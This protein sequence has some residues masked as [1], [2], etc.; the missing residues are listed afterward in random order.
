MLCRVVKVEL[1]GTNRTHNRVKDAELTGSQCTDHEA[2]RDETRGAQLVVADLASNVAETLH[3]GP[4][5]TSAG[6]VHLRQQGV[7][8]VRDDSGDHTGHDTRCQ[9]D[10]NVGAGRQL[11]GGLAHAVVDPLCGLALHGEFGHGVGDLLEQDGAETGVETH[12]AIRGKHLGRTRAKALGPSGVRYGTDAHG[13]ERAQKQIG[14][15]LSHG[16]RGQVNRSA[17]VPCL[18]LA[19]LLCHVDLEELHTTELEPTLDEVTCG[20][21]TQTRGKSADTL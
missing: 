11:R 14:N 12:D 10:L 13:L 6:L 9:T 18:L 7:G 20:G 5:A 15:E 8:R 16:R 3:N 1:G 21:G 17:V 2:T 19:Q 4:S